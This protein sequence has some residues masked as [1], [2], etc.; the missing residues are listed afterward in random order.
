MRKTPQGWH[1]VL[2]QY[3]REPARCIAVGD[4]L[5][6]RAGHGNGRLDVNK[7][8]HT[9][10]GADESD[11]DD[12][13]RK[14][15]GYRLRPFEYDAYCTDEA[16]GTIGLTV[17]FCCLVPTLGRGEQAKNGLPRKVPYER[18]V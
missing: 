11:S 14:R 8:E 4:E 6:A 7:I 13:E 3:K 18:Y 17:L 9:E 5:L 12:A 1:G 10:K 15:R 2:E 16:V